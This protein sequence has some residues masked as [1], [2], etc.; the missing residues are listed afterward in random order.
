MKKIN[1][2]FVHATGGLR[3]TAKSPDEALG[4]LFDQVQNLRVY[5]DGKTFPDL[6]PRRRMKA[7]QQEY[8]LEKKDPN[9][10]LHEFVSRHFYEFNGG[11]AGS[12]QT[13]PSMTAREHIAV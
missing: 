1:T 9:F 12:Y 10:D 11:S 13:D 5:S 7:I 4:E 3:V 8:L 2:T 6:V